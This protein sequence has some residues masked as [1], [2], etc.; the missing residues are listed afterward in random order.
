MEEETPQQAPPPPPPEINP[1]I[2]PVETTPDPMSLI[3]KANA[4]AERLEASN[5]EL[6]RL[7]VIQQDTIIK[8]KLAG[9]ATA[10]VTTQT[11]EDKDI[12]NAKKLLEGTGMEELVFPKK[13]KTDSS[14]N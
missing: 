14:Y 13:P 9:K 2:P 1:A 3:D 4:A 8:T 10:G 12:E 7:L 6:A 11:K 5:K